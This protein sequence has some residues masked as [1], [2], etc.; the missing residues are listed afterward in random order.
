MPRE[1]AEVPHMGVLATGE[2]ESLQVTSDMSG[3]VVMGCRMAKGPQFVFPVLQG[4]R[5]EGVQSLGGSCLLHS[6]LGCLPS[7]E[8]G[9]RN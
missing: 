9:N 3:A 6:Q 2:G 7:L 4:G 8:R 5:M 1:W